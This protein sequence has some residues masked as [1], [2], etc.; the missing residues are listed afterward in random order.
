MGYMTSQEE[1]YLLSTPV[2]QQWLAQGMV[3]GVVQL[4]QLRGLIDKQ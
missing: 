2:Y 1:D 3:E 4:A